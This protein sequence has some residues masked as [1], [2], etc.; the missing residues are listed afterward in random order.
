MAAS[1]PYCTSTTYG[2]AAP[3]AGGPIRFGID[4]GLAGSAG[5][6]QLPSKPEDPARELAAV[7]SLRPSGRTLVVR[8]NRLFLS[9]GTAGIEHFAQL[10]S[11]YSRAGFDVEI[12]VRYHPTSTE[13]GD[14]AAWT[15]YVRRV[16]DRLGPIPHVIAMTITNEVN[17]SFSPNTSDGSY[18]GA[19]DA[20]I[21][22]VEAAHDEA[23]RDGLPGLR[24]GFTYA[25]RFSPQGDA[26]FFT[27]LRTHGGAALQRALGFVGLDFYP[28]SVYPPA[29]APGEHY[30][31]ELA[32]A[33]GVLRDCF[34][35]LGGI[36]A[37]IPIWITENGIPTG[38]QSESQQAAALAELVR[39]AQA[40]SATFNISDYRWFNL[41]DSVTG[42]PV[43]LI[44]ASFATDGLLRDDYSAKPS[45]GEY[46][47]LIAQLGAHS[48]SPGV[49][50][51]RRHQSARRRR[52]GRR[53]SRPGHGRRRALPKESPADPR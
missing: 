35:P 9:D 24:F 16:V 52:S 19:Q 13:N 36:G 12:Q 44:G 33:A 40:Y 21:Q 14:I 26:G 18:Q 51:S 25:Y 20:L 50:S 3:R 43:G 5:G 27:Y 42:S 7:G 37:N 41:R 4:P 47:A 46:R 15:R 23:R 10:A 17:L 2:A 6:V 30:R 29:M 39:A 38:T 48:S 53:R 34:A 8:L 49:G 32:Q 45:F 1:D 31:S 11:S 22:G 28:G